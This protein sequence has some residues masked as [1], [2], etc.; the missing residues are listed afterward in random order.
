MAPVTENDALDPLANTEAQ[1]VRSARELRADGSTFAEIGRILDVSA[2]TVN[3]WLNPEYKAKQ[4]AAT[5]RQ[6][7][8]R[9]SA[10]VMVTA[11]A[12][13]CE[14]ERCT[15]TDQYGDERCVYCGKRPA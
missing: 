1:R 2:A 3:Y 5:A 9:A 13:R 6:N 4:R 14:K 10:T 12:C 7:A 15:E 8:R 11:P